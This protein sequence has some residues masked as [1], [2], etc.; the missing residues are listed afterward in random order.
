MD[1]KEESMKNAKKLLLVVLL[2]ELTIM[3]AAPAEKKAAAHNIVVG[4]HAG[5]NYVGGE[6]A[7]IAIG[8]DGVVGDE[9]TIRIGTEGQQNRTFLAGVHGVRP[10]GGGVVAVV[11]D[12]NGQLGTVPY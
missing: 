9:D 7:N 11:I 3:N 8:N 12:S 4:P 10:G 2:G 5:G 6:K 1:F